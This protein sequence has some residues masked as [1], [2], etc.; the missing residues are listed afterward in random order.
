MKEKTPIRKRKTRRKGAA[1]FIEFAR[2]RKRVLFLGRINF[3]YTIAQMLPANAFHAIREGV[4][5]LDVSA[6]TESIL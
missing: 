4:E 2:R 3:F 6:Q 1:G 5:G